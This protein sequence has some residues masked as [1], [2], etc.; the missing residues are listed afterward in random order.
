MDDETSENDE[1]TQYFMDKEEGNMN[2]NDLIDEEKDC[3]GARYLKVVNHISFSD[4]AIFT[5]ELPLSK[6]GTPEVK[7]AKQTEVKNL[8]DYDVFEEV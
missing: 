3:I 8:M 6:H 4:Y 7:E 5:V 1:T 2:W